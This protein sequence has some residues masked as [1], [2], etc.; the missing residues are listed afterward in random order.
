VI[1]HDHN[2]QT[3]FD[4]SLGNVLMGAATIR[5]AGVH[6]QV[7]NDFVHVLSKNSHREH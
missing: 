4:G 1:C 2:V 5:V 7:N 3:G 6:M